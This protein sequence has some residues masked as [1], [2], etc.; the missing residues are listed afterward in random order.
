MLFSVFFDKGVEP[1]V[2]VV[3][4]EIHKGSKLWI[5]GFVT[6][7]TLAVLRPWIKLV[8]VDKMRD[9]MAKLLL[10]CRNISS[11]PGPLFLRFSPHSACRKWKPTLYLAC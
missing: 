10:F 3:F 7:W 2:L 1:G 8:F 6:C 5:E 9:I 4:W 11:L